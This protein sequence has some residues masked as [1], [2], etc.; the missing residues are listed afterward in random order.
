[1]PPDVLTGYSLLY[2]TPCFT[3]MGSDMSEENEGESGRERRVKGK[4]RKRRGTA[5]FCFTSL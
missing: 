1:V 3:F 5:D 2:V 4:C